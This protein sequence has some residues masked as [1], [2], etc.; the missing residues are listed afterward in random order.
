MFLLSVAKLQTAL[1]IR[2]TPK[3][4]FICF[5]ATDI[6]AAPNHVNATHNKNIIKILKH[7]SSHNFPVVHQKLKIKALGIAI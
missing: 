6:S 1:L 5:V 4:R 3:S 2:K 7:L